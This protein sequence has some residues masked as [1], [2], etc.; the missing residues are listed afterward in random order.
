M[1]K[2]GTKNKRYKYDL[3]VKIPRST[4][5]YLSR[6][7]KLKII[8]NKDDDKINS[9]STCQVNLKILKGK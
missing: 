9:I 3:S 5:Y 7:K 4:R 1:P 2:I 6:K 8:K